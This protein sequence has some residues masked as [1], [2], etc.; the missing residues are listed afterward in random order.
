MSVQERQKQ[1]MRGCEVDKNVQ[2]PLSEKKSARNAN[3]VQWSG[4]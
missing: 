1:L 4:V 3:K 2:N